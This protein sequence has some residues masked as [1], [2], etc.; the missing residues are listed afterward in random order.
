MD[1]F[2]DLHVHSTASDG[3]MSPAEL[4]RYASSRGLSAIALTDHDTVLGVESAE[5]EGKKVGLEVIPGVEI[6]VLFKPEMHI[7]G[8]FFSDDYMKIRPVL[9]KLRKNREERNPK[10]INKLNEMGFDITMEEVEQEA[11]GGVVGRLHIAKILTSKGYVESVQEAFEKYLSHGRPAYF[12]KE[13]LLPE[14]GIR[15]ITR[16]G[17]IAVLAHPVHLNPDFEQL[18]SLLNKLVMAGLKGMEVYYVDNTEIETD[19]LLRLAKKHNLLPTGG[20]DFHGVY[21]PDIEI[22]KGRGNLKLPYS[23]LDDLKNITT[24]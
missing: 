20:S 6:S 10:I 1:K 16:T 12:S 21:K 9:E 2:I 8:Y 24:C 4:V 18:D 11:S 17:G 15:E 14:E 22:G 23:M 13:K 5:D 3:S 7:L 19:N